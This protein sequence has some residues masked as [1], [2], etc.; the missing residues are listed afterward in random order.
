MKEDRTNTNGFANDGGGNGVF[1]KSHNV[2][3]GTGGVGGQ[4]N[5]GVIGIRNGGGGG[6]KMV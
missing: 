3:A 4:V 2:G 1:Q 5:K 6:G